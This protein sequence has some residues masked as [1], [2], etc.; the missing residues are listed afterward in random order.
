MFEFFRRLAR[1]RTA[2]INGRVL[3]LRV[4]FVDFSNPGLVFFFQLSLLSARE[5]GIGVDMQA[6]LSSGDS[7]RHATHHIS[8]AA[9]SKAPISFISDQI[10]L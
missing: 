3:P 1:C 5:K 7:G 10:I 6:M 4:N 9:P 8:V 2:L